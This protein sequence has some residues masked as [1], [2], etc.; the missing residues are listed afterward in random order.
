MS[1]PTLSTIIFTS[2]H[3]DR[4][5]MIR[6]MNHIVHDFRGNVTSRGGCKCVVIPM[7]LPPNTGPSSVLNGRDRHFGII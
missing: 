4:M 5:S 2:T 1:I 3:S 7:I 6:D